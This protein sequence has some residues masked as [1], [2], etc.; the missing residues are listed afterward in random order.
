MSLIKAYPQMR[1]QV[2]DAECVLNMQRKVSR[3]IAVFSLWVQSD[4][5]QAMG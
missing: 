1:G 3:R 5:E 4:L 2:G